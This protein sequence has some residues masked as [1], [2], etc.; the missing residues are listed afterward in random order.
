MDEEGV[1]VASQSIKQQLI[2]INSRGRT[3]AAKQ[4]DF[5]KPNACFTTNNLLSWAP[6]LYISNLWTVV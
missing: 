6:G 2:V 1:A 5:N 3:A 4:Q